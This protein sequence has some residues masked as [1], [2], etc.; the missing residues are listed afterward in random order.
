[1]SKHGVFYRIGDAILSFKLRRPRF[2]KKPKS[3]DEIPKI[4]RGYF[5]KRC[6]GWPEY[7][8]LKTQLALLGLIASLALHLVFFQQLEVVFL[9]AMGLFS[10]Y[11][12]LLVPT[13]IKRAFREDYP[14]Y[15][16]FVALNLGLVWGFWLAVRHVFPAISTNLAYTLAF[17]ALS[18]VPVVLLAYAGFRIRYGRDYTFGVVESV[19]GSKAL[20]RIGYDICSSVK[21]GR[22]LVESL[23]T[24][25][26][27]DRVKIA[28]E[29]SLFSLRGSRIGAIVEVVSKGGKSRRTPG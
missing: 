23:V 9:A 22:C 11:A 8:I 7:V 5:E 3:R 13:Q 1:M 12:V 16:A 19:R 14:A 21:P 25:R 6:L 28:V 10:A 29:R 4:L 26:P 27:G 24:T 17:P 2:S 15:R 20:V 18:V